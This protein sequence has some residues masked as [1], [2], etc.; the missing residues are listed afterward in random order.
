M[1]TAEAETTPALPDYVLD[2]DAVL[3]DTDAEWR[4]KRVPNYSK[5]RTF[6]EEGTYSTRRD[7]VPMS[8]P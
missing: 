3:K 2:P 1:S 8:R 5:T 6:F 4:Y 7:T